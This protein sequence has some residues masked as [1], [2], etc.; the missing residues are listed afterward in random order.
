MTFQRSDL[1]TNQFLTKSQEKLDFS[2]FK[3]YFVNDENSKMK[4]NLEENP[5]L[6]KKNLDKNPMLTN[7]VNK[8]RQKIGDKIERYIIEKFTK[9]ELALASSTEEF[10]TEIEIPRDDELLSIMVSSDFDTNFMAKKM[11]FIRSIPQY[12]CKEYSMPLE[13]LR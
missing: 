12:E 5:M 6:T 9:M 13:E 4:N 7:K 3:L 2:N 10:I 8:L 11:A 1:N